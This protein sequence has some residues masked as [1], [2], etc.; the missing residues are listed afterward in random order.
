M[1]RR[2]R[3]DQAEPERQIADE[4]RAARAPGRRAPRC[5]RR[6]SDGGARRR[7][8]QSDQQQ[9]RERRAARGSAARRRSACGSRSS[10]ARRSL[11][12]RRLQRL[13]RPGLVSSRSSYRIGVIVLKSSPCRR[14]PAARQA[15]R[16]SSA[17]SADPGS[18]RRLG[19][20]GWRA[21]SALPWRACRGGARRTRSCR[22]RPRCVG[23][24]RS[25]LGVRLDH[26]VEPLD[27][28]PC[29]RR[30]R[31]W[32][33]AERGVGGGKEQRRIGRRACAPGRR[34]A[35]ASDR[36]SARASRSTV[37]RAAALLVGARDAAAIDGSARRS[38][39]GCRWRREWPVLQRREAEVRVG[40]AVRPVAACRQTHARADEQQDREKERRR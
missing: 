32:L 25:R 10:E 6:L 38:R 18:C 31:S 35:T 4:R 8:H 30:R 16:E 12:P 7:Q 33:V 26:A 5:M 21:A 15:G 22:R 23:S 34:R 14:R 13:P 37:A 11:S 28:R 1:S 3:E 20:S 29:D 36:C 17:P 9:R 2:E 40:E 19:T 39:G 27:A 24:M